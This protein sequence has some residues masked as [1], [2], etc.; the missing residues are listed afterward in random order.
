[1]EQSNTIMTIPNTKKCSK[2]VL[3]NGSVAGDISLVKIASDRRAV[4][5]VFSAQVFAPGSAGSGQQRI[6]QAIQMDSP[7]RST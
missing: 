2:V 1:M 7:A 4:L 6:A 3:I 5:A